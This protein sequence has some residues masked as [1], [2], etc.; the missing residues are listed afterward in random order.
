MTLE[1]VKKFFTDCDHLF[2]VRSKYFSLGVIWPLIV[3]VGVLSALFGYFFFASILMVAFA[4]NI[5]VESHL[6]DQVKGTH[7]ENLKRWKAVREEVEFGVVYPA[8]I[9]LSG[10]EFLDTSSVVPDGAISYLMKQMRGLSQEKRQRLESQCSFLAQMIEAYNLI[11]DEHIL[12]LNELTAAADQAKAGSNE[13]V[14][15]ALEKVAELQ[16]LCVVSDYDI[17]DEH[18]LQLNE[19][20]AAADQAKAMADEA[21]AAAQAKVAQ[22]ESLGADLSEHRYAGIECGDY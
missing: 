15:T 4:I 18:I 1:E 9:A 14:A 6:S 3:T 19:L 10:K 22:L 8:L 20:K 13:V 5:S 2:P 16:S 12:Q 17:T 21:I 11:I 7:K